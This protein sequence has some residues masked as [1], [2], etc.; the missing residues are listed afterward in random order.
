MSWL[1]CWCSVDPWP[2][3]SVA[4]STRR[5]GLAM[6][7]LAA[8]EPCSHEIKVVWT[9]IYEKGCSAIITSSI[10]VIKVRSSCSRPVFWWSPNRTASDTQGTASDNGSHRAVSKPRSYFCLIAK[11]H[12]NWDTSWG[13]SKDAAHFPARIGNFLFVPTAETCLLTA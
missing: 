3:P 1:T 12:R 10:T 9:Q 6:R 2:T 11:G 13:Y 8:S 5:V 7:R 4:C